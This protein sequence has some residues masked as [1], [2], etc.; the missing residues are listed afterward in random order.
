MNGTLIG[1]L[2]GIAAVVIVYFVVPW[3][4]KRM[5]RRRMVKRASTAGSVVLT[6]DDGP[7]PES[8]PQILDILRLYRLKAAFFVLGERAK[9]YPDLVRRMVAEGH[10]V[11][12]HGFAHAH[13]WA[14]PPIAYLRDLL[15]GRRSVEAVVDRR[16]PRFMRPAY[17]KLNALTVGYACVSGTRMVL[18]T[19]DPRDYEANSPEEVC[20]RV[21]DSLGATPSGIVLLHDGRRRVGHSSVDVTVRAVHELCARLS[22]GAARFGTLGDFMDGAKRSSRHSGSV[23]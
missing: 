22:G 5:L 8:T 14:T 19:V 15:R 11:G 9:K 20:T 10:D 21:V 16:G 18:W 7:D 17:G 4:L 1:A 2:A 3:F 23:S 6:F 12:D 13:P